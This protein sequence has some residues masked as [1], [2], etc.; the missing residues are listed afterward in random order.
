MLFFLLATVFCTQHVLSPDNLAEEVT[1]GFSH[2]QGQFKVEISG[3]SVS[4][5]EKEKDSPILK[6][7]FSGG[8]ITD[9]WIKC[10]DKSKIFEP[11]FSL[12]SFSSMRSC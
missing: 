12:K 3:R 5:S 2:L 9:T 8:T 1:K 4:I 10:N 6:F 11:S 7:N